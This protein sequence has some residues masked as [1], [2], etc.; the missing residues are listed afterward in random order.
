VAQCENH[1]AFS[2]VALGFGWTLWEYGQDN[3]CSHYPELVPIW[4]RPVAWDE[5]Q[6]VPIGCLCCTDLNV[7]LTEWYE[8]QY[9]VM[10]SRTGK[11]MSNPFEGHAPLA[12]PVDGGFLPPYRPR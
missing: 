8:E 12:P 6:S 2:K 10:E 1:P 11:V 4:I 3:T 9:S 5:E 7:A